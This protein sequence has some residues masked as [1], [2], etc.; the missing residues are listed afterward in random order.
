[1][2]RWFPENQDRSNERPDLRSIPE[3]RIR[4]RADPRNAYYSTDDGDHRVA[5]SYERARTATKTTM[6]IRNRLAVKDWR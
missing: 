6:A 4:R 5:P 3:S 2:T 1:M